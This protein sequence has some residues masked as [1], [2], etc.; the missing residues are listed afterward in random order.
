MGISIAVIKLYTIT[1]RSWNTPMA[2][3]T[4]CHGGVDESV[5]CST[6]TSKAYISATP[7]TATKAPWYLLAAT[8]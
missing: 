4:A 6:I 3:L 7:P 1:Q 8:A 5:A 2:L